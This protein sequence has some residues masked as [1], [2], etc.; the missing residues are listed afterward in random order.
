MG[1]NL[2][3]RPAAYCTL[4]WRGS[5]NSSFFFFFLG[6]VLSCCRGFTLQSIIKLLYLERDQKKKCYLHPIS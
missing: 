6:S 2:Q 5:D 3:E 4:P 1:D